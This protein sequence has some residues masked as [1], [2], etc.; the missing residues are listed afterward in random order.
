MTILAKR[1]DFLDKETNLGVSDFITAADSNIRN[2]EIPDIQEVSDT[3]SSFLSPIND[4]INQGGD[5]IDG[6]I[7]N[8]LSGIDL[9]DFSPSEFFRESKDLLGIMGDIAK[10]PS[11]LL[12]N[13]LD[14][15]FPGGGIAKNLAK[16]IFKVCN[17]AGGGFGNMRPFDVGMD[18]NGNSL[19]G[20]KGN[21]KP[22]GISNLLD[23]LT[24]GAYG[25][26]SKDINAL[27][28]AVMGVALG[29][30]DANMCGGFT[31]ASSLLG[32][33]KNA[34]NRAGVL[35][36]SGLSNK[37]NVRGM[38]DV[39]NTADPS[40]I[41]IQNPS[42]LKGLV[43]NPNVSENHYG[44]NGTKPFMNQFGVDSRGINSIYEGITAGAGLL[45]E[46]WN[47]SNQGNLSLGKVT[48]STLNK[49]EGNIGLSSLAAN[50]LRSNNIN[51]N[52][53]NNV[54]RDMSD[55]LSIAFAALN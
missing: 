32:D 35:T 45:D 4:V 19:A 22:S 41:N 8:A 11:K 44:E 5:G 16:S 12:D 17:S 6:A 48:N 7:S 28:N 50:K 43:G 30:Y 51:I 34:L 1:F 52:N 36:M 53:L 31:A 39:L 38:M 49:I 2:I 15:L 40:N 20:S 46:N 23:A 47:K 13:L 29:S 24:G 3:L 21:C 14:G 9:G 27:V 55:T 42:A 54:N 25:K 10:M 33:N 26:G 37:H 18:C